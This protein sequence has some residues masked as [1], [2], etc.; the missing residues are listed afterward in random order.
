MKKYQHL[1]KKVQKIQT[2][3]NQIKNKAIILF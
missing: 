3:K 2:E 1:L